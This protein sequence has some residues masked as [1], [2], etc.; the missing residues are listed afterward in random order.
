MS[1]VFRQ[2]VRNYYFIRLNPVLLSGVF[3]QNVRTY[4]FIRLNTALLSGTLL[5]RIGSVSLI[6]V[7]NSVE[8]SV[9]EKVNLA[10]DNVFLIKIGYI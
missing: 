9:A 6:L 5:I 4:Y 2:N 10:T 3:R 1:G 7:K 8:I